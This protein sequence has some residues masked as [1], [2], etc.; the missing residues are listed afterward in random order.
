MRR[1]AQSCDEIF[2]NEF[3]CILKAG[4]FSPLE[5]QAPRQNFLLHEV[6]LYR[7]MKHGVRL[8][9]L[10]ETREKIWR[11]MHY[12]IGHWNVGPTYDFITNRFSWHKIRLDAINFVQSCDVRGNRNTA[13]HKELTGRIPISDIFSTWSIDYAGP[14]P[15][16]KNGNQYF[17]IGM[18]I[19]L[20]VL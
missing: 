6:R 16:T 10:I 17:I 11:V 15:K 8:I 1:I 5:Y 18:S 3:S 12:E 13:N 4:I 9:P 14:L 7:R 19:L 20:N 2:L